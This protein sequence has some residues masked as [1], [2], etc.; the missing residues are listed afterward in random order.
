MTVSA[1]NWGDDEHAF[2]RKL[3]LPEE[4]RRQLGMAWK[5]GYRWFRSPNVVPIERWR[6]REQELEGHGSQLSPSTN[7]PT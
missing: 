3:V 2:W 5:G 4:D 1:Q 7:P 6:G